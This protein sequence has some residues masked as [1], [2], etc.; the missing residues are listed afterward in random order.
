M[1]DMSVFEHRKLN[2]IGKDYVIT[3]RNMYRSVV[4]FSSL[5]CKALELRWPN[6]KSIGTYILE[7]DLFL[8]KRVAG[9]TCLKKPVR[10]ITEFGLSKS[11]FA[12]STHKA[13]YDFQALLQALTSL[14][15]RQ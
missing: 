1:L 9:G 14:R 5:V 12:I 10:K 8:H 15:H 13:L 4:Q 6:V 11:T 7:S 3:I 2:R